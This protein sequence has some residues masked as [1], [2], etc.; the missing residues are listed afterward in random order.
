M[1][2]NGHKGHV[3]TAKSPSPTAL[4]EAMKASGDALVNNPACTVNVK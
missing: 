3:L 1:M 2:V 4:V